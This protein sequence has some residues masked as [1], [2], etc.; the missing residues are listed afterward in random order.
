MPTYAVTAA[1]GK[2]APHALDAL[3]ARGVDAGDVVAVARTPV[4]AASLAARGF[5]VRE[6]DYG[7]PETLGAA[8]EGV[9][10]LLFVSGSEV[11]Q[12]VRQHRNV[13]DAAVAA[14]VEHVT[15]TSAPHADDTELVVAPEHK[16]TEEL[17]R[18]SGLGWT[19]ARNSWYAENYTDQLPGIVE[20]G[21]LLGAG[22]DGRVAVAPRADYA[23]AA[24]ATLVAAEPGTVH[25]L[26]GVRLTLADI[27]A[28]MADVTGRPVTYRDLPTPGDLAAALAGSGLDEATAGFLA[29]VDEAISRGDLDVPD[30]DLVALLGRPVT[31]F[32]DV[33]RA[34]AGALP[35]AV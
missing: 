28:T 5:V 9:R 18:A 33:V 12:R 23:E 34:A 2:F 30:S 13:V 35:A 24:V 16:A 10:R 3:L 31:P 14:G 32:A 26:G 15:Y 25:E 29:A 17:L 19:F 11:G 20:R 22:H 21:V 27:A 7:R 8:F 6:G 4:K 1:T